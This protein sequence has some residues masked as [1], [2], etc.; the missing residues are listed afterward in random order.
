M[1]NV[2][3]VRIDRKRHRGLVAAWLTSDHVARWWGDPEEGL[4]QFDSTADT[5]QALIA[6]DGVPMGYMRW[7]KVDPDALASVGLKNIPAGSVDVDIFVGPCNE[8][9]RGIGP[10]AL[11]CLFDLLRSTTN[12]PLAGLCTSIDNLRAHAAFE[13][14]GCQKFAQFQDPVYG[15]CYVYVRHLH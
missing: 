2:A 5:E 7:A 3:L 14:A 12:A 4:A 6:L 10:A 8:L 13:K 9:G 1:G 15:P 11:T